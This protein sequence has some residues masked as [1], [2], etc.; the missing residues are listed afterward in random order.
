VQQTGPDVVDEATDLVGVRHERAGLQPGDRLHHVGVRVGERLGRP[1]RPDPGVPLDLRLERVI[2]E[3]GHAA[4]GVVDEDDLPGAEQSLADHQGADHVVGD[5]AAGVA[6]D[7]RVAVREAERGAHV[8]PGVHAG[9]D[10]EV[11]RGLGRR[12]AGELAGV[13][14]VTSE[15]V[16]DHYQIRTGGQQRGA[17]NP[18]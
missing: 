3:L 8:E 12:G 14:P 13:L 17:T 10:R 6:D 15:Q 16:I 4:V 5:D 11:E 18:G 2:G 9:D 7:V 1:G